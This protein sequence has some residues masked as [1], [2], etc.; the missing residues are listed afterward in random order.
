LKTERI[1]AKASTKTQVLF[2]NNFTLIILMVLM[3]RKRCIEGR[4]GQ[5][6]LEVKWSGGGEGLRGLALRY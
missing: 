4:N 3:K 2:Q 6:A 5:R 1:V